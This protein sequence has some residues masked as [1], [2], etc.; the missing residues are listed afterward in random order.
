MDQ[1]L[2]TQASLDFD[3]GDAVALLRLEPVPVAS[4]GPGPAALVDDISDPTCP[5]GKDY[6]AEVGHRR[7]ALELLLDAAETCVKHP[8]SK[9]A[10]FEEHWL[11]GYE[12]DCAI[13]GSLA[14]QSLVGRDEIQAARVRFMAALKN[15]GASLLEALKDARRN[16]DRAVTV[17]DGADDSIPEHRVGAGERMRA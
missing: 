11:M 8:G 14:F 2:M 3:A 5:V 4:S 7:L 10:Q 16:F 12:D 17:I 1:A 15:D 13:S 9:E 6:F